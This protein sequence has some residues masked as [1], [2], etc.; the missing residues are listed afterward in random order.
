MRTLTLCAS[1]VICATPIT[2]VAG[3]PWEDLFGPGKG[4][5]WTD[6][7]ARFY[8]ELPVGWNGE[9]R[10]GASEVVDFYKTHPDNGFIAH[11]TVEM[12]TI[13]PNVKTAHYAVKVEDEVKAVAYGYRLMTKD[14]ITISGQT[15]HRTHF[16][17]Q[18]RKNTELTD[19]VIQSV[20]IMG[21]RAFVLTF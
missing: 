3:T 15:A 2:A 5:L 16:T 14:K 13:P 18:E 1:V 11:L 12:R 6:P 7:S 8:L 9:P 19:E 20:F 10:K 17:H 4:K 21:E